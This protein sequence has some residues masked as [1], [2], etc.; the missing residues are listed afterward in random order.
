MATILP[1]FPRFIARSRV[2]LA[3]CCAAALCV[4]LAHAQ[5]C[6]P[7]AEESPGG[8]DLV[9]RSIPLPTDT[10]GDLAWDG[11]ALWIADWQRGELLRFDPDKEQ[12]LERVTAPCYRP[13]GLAWGNGLLYVADDFEGAV[14]V[15]DPKTGR[16]I[17]RYL[18]PHKGGAGLAWDGEALWL[19]EAVDKTLQR[20]IPGDGTALTYFDSPQEDPGG[21]AFD[22]TYL[23]VTQRMQDRI[24]MV[25]PRSGK[26]ITSFDAPGPYP[27]G[28][29]P[30]PNGRL[31]VADSEKGT[32]SLCAPREGRGY[33]TSDWREAEVRMTYRIENQGPGEIVDAVIHFAVP[34]PE[35]ENQ[36]ILDPLT[37]APEAPELHADQWKQQV[38]TFR[39]A[40]IAPGERFEVGYRTR[41][42][43]GNLV[44]TVIPEKVGG[45]DKIPA[46]IRRDYTGDADRFQV[47]V[48][49]VS[50]TSARVVGD[51][52]NPYWIARKIYDWVIETLEYDR[53]GGWDVPETLIKRKTGSCSEYTFLFIGL[54]RAAGLPARYEGSGA[55]RGDDACVDDVYHRWAEVY[56]PGYG[57]VPFDPSGG[58]RPTPGGQA[59]YIGRVG[60][61]LFVTTHSGGGS[62]ALGWNYN[63][64]ASYSLNGRC[65]I[66]EDAWV[67]WRRAKEEGQAFI[68]S[69]AHLAP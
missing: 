59:D 8:N 48:P 11:S 16:T 17:T 6:V 32:L 62:T 14:Y 7:G 41:I 60:N 24:Y 23:W 67:A 66:T 36:V 9:L 4:G 29:A 2:V 46:D 31:W 43:L 20:L 50:E 39:R 56:L 38:A 13:R 27:C 47:K 61:R 22:G 55:L 57:W 19:A 40:R 1:L 65:A 21:L 58:D 53:V 51:E 42:K 3:L 10:P 5:S 34:E 18:T 25:D 15:F 69:G 63:A 52:K 44:Y 68:P 35:L 45:L 64:N 28:L 33:Q 26:A 12:V 54:C 37:Y 49:L 30:A